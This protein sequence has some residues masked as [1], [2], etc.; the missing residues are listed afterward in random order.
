MG[1]MRLA[2]PL[3]RYGQCLNPQIT[4]PANCVSSP[5]NDLPAVPVIL[6]RICHGGEDGVAGIDVVH[7]ATGTRIHD[8]DILGHFLRVGVPDVDDGA[9]FGVEVWVAA[10]KALCH[11]ACGEGDDHF[12]VGVLCS[13]GGQSGGNCVVGHFALV[14]RGEGCRKGKGEAKGKSLGFHGR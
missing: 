5:I 11:E 10:L 8:L 9:T 13:T 3:W 7:A 6:G 4:L 1:M 12:R 14:G 2:L